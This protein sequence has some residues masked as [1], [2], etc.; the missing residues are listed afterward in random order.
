MLPRWVEDHLA[1]THSPAMRPYWGFWGLEPLSSTHCSFPHHLHRWSTG[2]WCEETSTMGTWQSVP[3]MSSARS[4]KSWHHPA[5]VPKGLGSRQ[6]KTAGLGFRSSWA[7]VRSARGRRRARR[8]QGAISWRAQE[9]STGPGTVYPWW[10]GRGSSRPP[11]RWTLARRQAGH[12]RHCRRTRRGRHLQQPVDLRRRTRAW[13]RGTR[14]SDSARASPRR[15]C[16]RRR[17]GTGAG[18]SPRSSRLGGSSGGPSHRGW[19]ET[20]ASSVG[21]CPEPATA[22]SYGVWGRTTQVSQPWNPRNLGCGVC[23]SGREWRRGENPVKTSWWR[24]KW[25]GETRGGDADAETVDVRGPTELKPLYMSVFTLESIWQIK[26]DLRK[27]III[28]LIGK[29]RIIG[30]T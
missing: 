28:F 21:A 10:R 7:A 14:P 25:I 16:G 11:C 3:Q 30:K 24:R 22:S 26:N 20:A 27:Y 5:R 8:G 4:P 23:L 18:G 9:W 17:Q 6:R 19:P 12:R 15:R 2:T 1:S 13:S 29:Y